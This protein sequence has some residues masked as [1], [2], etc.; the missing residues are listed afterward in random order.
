MVVVPSTT[1]ISTET[2]SSVATFSIPIAPKIAGKL[3]SPW[4]GYRSVNGVRLGAKSR[5]ND[6][7]YGHSGGYAGEVR[8]IISKNIVVFFTTGPKLDQATKYRQ[9]VME[10]F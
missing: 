6:R 5:Y 10:K 9:A 1:V 7:P 8:C 2:L 3:R 4:Y